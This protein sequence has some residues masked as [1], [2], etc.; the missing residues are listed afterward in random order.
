MVTFY[1][2]IES[3]LLILNALAILNEDRF[4]KRVGLSV[5]TGS[6]FDPQSGSTAKSKIASTLSAVRLLLRFPL[7]FINTTVILLL[8]LFG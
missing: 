2:M 3:V 4:L 5:A 7:I 8:F 6:D 1:G